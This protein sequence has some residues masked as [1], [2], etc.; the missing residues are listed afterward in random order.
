ML[1][2][3]NHYH[4]E[5]HEDGERKV[6]FR[7][8]S[9]PSVVSGRHRAKRPGMAISEVVTFVVNILFSS[10]NVPQQAEVKQPDLGFNDFYEW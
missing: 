8:P 1:N 6:F 3:L 5:E 7:F 2:T 9:C 4:H 10:F